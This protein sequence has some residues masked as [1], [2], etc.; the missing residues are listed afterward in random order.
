MAHLTG[1][2]QSS[3]PPIDPVGCTPSYHGIQGPGG[4]SSGPGDGRIS[5]AGP[6]AGIAGLMPRVAGALRAAED[7]LDDL[8]DLDGR[9]PFFDCLDP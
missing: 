3:I 7:R 9:D 8:D 1:T 4:M 5:S 6:A 2:P